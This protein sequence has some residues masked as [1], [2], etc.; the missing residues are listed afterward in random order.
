MKHLLTFLL[1]LA[2]A[3]ARAQTIDIGA[4]YNITWTDS[5]NLDVQ[6]N[7]ADSAAIKTRFPNFLERLRFLYNRNPRGFGKQALG[8][9]GSVLQLSEFVMAHND[10]VWSGCP[11][12]T[13]GCGS[14]RDVLDPAGKFPINFPLHAANQRS[15]GQGSSPFY[16]LPKG[17][18]FVSVGSTE[19]WLNRKDWLGPD[20]LMNIFQS[21][22]Y[23]NAGIFAYSE[24]TVIEQYNLDGRCGDWLIDSYHSSGIAMW[25]MGECSEIHNVFA[26]HF[27]NSGFE[28]VRGTPN[29]VFNCSSFFNN[30][31]GYCVIGGSQGTHRFI[32]T[33]GD[34][35]GLALYGCIDGYNRPGGGT[36][37]INGQKMETNGDTNAVDEPG[38]PQVF[39]RA[40]APGGLGIYLN[41][42]FSNISCRNNGIWID[43]EILIDDLLGV[44][45]TIDATNF[46]GVDYKNV[47]RVAGKRY[48]VPY[49]VYGA[50]SFHYTSANGGQFYGLFENSAA[51]IISSSC[52][53]QLNGL[54]RNPETGQPIGSFDYTACTPAYDPHGPSGGSCTYTYSEWGPCING[55]HT[56]TV[57]NASPPGCTGTPV[58]SESCAVPANVWRTNFTSSGLS[59]IPATVYTLGPSALVQ[60]QTTKQATSI[61]NG[62]I[63]VSGT[64]P[65]AQYPLSV[66]GVR[67]VVITGFKATALNNGYVLD[68]VRLD[69]SGNFVVTGATLVAPVPAPV[70][71]NATN[72]I[73]LYFSAPVNIGY[74][75]NGTTSSNAQYCA[76]DQLQLYTAY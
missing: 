33:S 44:T 8:F 5:S 50:P 24:A 71:I 53:A 27:N 13:A 6:Y 59:N 69:A 15:T 67:K 11:D 70:A 48:S 35:N 65:G 23:G 29:T 72:T 57:I 20:S 32:T 62:I 30:E 2:M 3:I 16:Y 4:T 10:G 68:K 45:N 38:K 12:Y 66:A 37:T 55:T 47:L 51:T 28:L 54:P 75:Y 56:R 22:V 64:R 17:A 63:N 73:T 40:W 1:C 42:G 52:I 18:G 21:S 41:A 31:Y 36:W 58:L 26:H 76:M 14:R 39:F 25:D 7:A 74:L 49:Q 60:S 34:A 19:L 46:A 43:S 9:W 61:A